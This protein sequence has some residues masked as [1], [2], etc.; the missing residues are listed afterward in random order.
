MLRFAP[1]YQAAPWGG[2][3]LAD[4][5]ERE[6]PEDRIG[7]SW[8]LVSLEDYQSTCIAGRFEGQGLQDLWESGRLGGK[9]EGPFPFL[10]KWLDTHDWLSVQVHPD[11]AA[12][13]TLGKGRPKTEVWLVAHQDPNSVILLGHYPGIDAATLK[14]AA[15]GGTVQKWMYE[16]QPRVGEMLK[17]PA[18]TLHAV[19]PGFLLLEVQQP[20]DTTYRVYDWDR[21]GLDGKPRE[22]HLEE[23]CVAI[24][25]EAHGAHRIQ[26]QEV[27]GPGFHLAPIKKG[28]AIAPGP[29]RV[30]V[31]HSGDVLLETAQGPFELAYGDVAVAEPADESIQFKTGTCVLITDDPQAT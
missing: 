18:G 8:E 22:L 21:P 1:R 11:E 6:L 30:L 29:L 25:F 12:C 23:A 7:E 9:A 14:Q 3:R 13:A 5:F 2:C 4:E 17:V 16:T 31:A 10:L 27:S 20:S 26:R 19:G 24:N 15:A 28:K